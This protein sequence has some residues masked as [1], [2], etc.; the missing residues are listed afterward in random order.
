MLKVPPSAK[1][2]TK[3]PKYRER[4]NCRKVPR[5]LYSASG[6]GLGYRAKRLRVP[7][8]PSATNYRSLPG[9]PQ[10]PRLP[11]R[12]ETTAHAQSTAECPKY[13]KAPKVPQGAERARSNAKYPRHCKVPHV[14]KCCKALQGVILQAPQVLQSTVQCHTCPNHR[15]AS[16]VLQR[17]VPIVSSKHWRDHVQASEVRRAAR[18]H[19]QGLLPRVTPLGHTHWLYTTVAPQG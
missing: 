11:R 13:C 12:I 8:T 19:T 6:R 14:T 1:S 10:V 7:E 18:D 3:C 9:V 2:T 4:P 16:K 17:P 15:H 5:V